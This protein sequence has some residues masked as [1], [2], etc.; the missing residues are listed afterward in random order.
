MINRD[1]DTQDD[2]YGLDVGPIQ[3]RLGSFSATFVH[4][5]WVTEDDGPGPAE[6]GAVGGSELAEENQV[7][8]EENNMLKLKVELLLDMLSNSGADTSRPTD[9]D[10]QWEQPPP[11]RGCRQRRN[12]GGYD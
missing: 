6:V 12:C 10:D 9:S 3:R 1:I 2:E 4:G 11:P 5:R 8:R 7:L